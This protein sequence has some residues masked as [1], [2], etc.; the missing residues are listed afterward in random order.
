MRRAR[1][2]LLLFVLIVGGFLGAGAVIGS[3][4]A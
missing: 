1:W 3:V 2:W 4:F